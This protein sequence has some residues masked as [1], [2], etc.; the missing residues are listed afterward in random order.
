MSATRSIPAGTIFVE[1]RG[2]IERVM[3]IVLVRPVLGTGRAPDLTGV[4]VE[5]AIRLREPLARRRRPGWE[6][7]W[8]TISDRRGAASERSRLSASR[9]PDPAPGSLANRQGRAGGEHWPRRRESRH[10]LPCP[11]IRAEPTT[12]PR[13]SSTAA[14]R[15][16]RRLLGPAAPAHGIHS[17]GTRSQKSA[18][19]RFNDGCR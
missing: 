2:W 18:T 4:S 11:D 14:T 10:R 13:S 7:R 8:P 16:G 12:F 17:G 19:T 3:R 9:Q 5:L 1:V 6:S 15:G